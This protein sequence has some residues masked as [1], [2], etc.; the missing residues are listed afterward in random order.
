[1]NFTTILYE[2]KDRIATVT[3]NRP[4]AYNAFNST[5]FR[6]IEHV[7]SLIEKDDEVL[8]VV[9]TGNDKAFAAGADLTQVAGIDSAN[10]AFKFVRDIDAFN[11]VEDLKKPVIAAV[12]GLALGGGCELS[13]CCDII[14]AADNAIFGQPEINVGFIP[15]GGGT[16]R[17]PRLI[18]VPRAKDLIYT[19]DKFDANE[20]FRMGLVSRVYP[21]ETC[22]EEVY[23]LAKNISEKPPLAIRAAKI[24]INDGINMDM[25]SAVAYEARCFETLFWTEDQ[26]EGAKAF[27]EK[28]KP[29]FQGR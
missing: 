28:R 15:G 14:I 7:F 20:A 9:I 11:R 19:G 27:V 3:L 26:T 13:M 4:K 2:K 29:N 23:K 10:E 24:A 21:L 22:M 16:Q 8:V 1:M 25:R 18:G 5:V 6:E 17:L 12:R